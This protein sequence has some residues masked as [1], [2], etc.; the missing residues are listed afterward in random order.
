M[1]ISTCLMKTVAVS[2]IVHFLVKKVIF[3]CAFL[4]ICTPPQKIR[5]PNCVATTKQINETYVLLLVI[6]DKIECIDCHFAYSICLVR[7]LSLKSR[8]FMVVIGESRRPLHASDFHRIH[9]YNVQASVVE[10]LFRSLYKIFFAVCICC[11][12]LV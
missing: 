5:S 8:C 10:N 4:D 11:Y 9:K 2:V 12:K 3:L 1:A 7:M 6:L